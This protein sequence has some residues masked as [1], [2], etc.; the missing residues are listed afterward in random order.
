VA[1]AESLD[2]ILINAAITHPLREWLIALRPNG[3]LMVPFAIGESPASWKSLFVRI[4]RMESN[5][6]AEP[7]SI[8]N[9]YPS[10]TMRSVA[11]QARLAAS[12]ASKAIGGLRSLR[13]DPHVET[14]TCIVHSDHF[15]LS[16]LD[17]HQSAAAS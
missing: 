6:S 17:A 12:V 5:F 15:C 8:F 4:K 1:G 10:A 16:A 14:A 2:A 13:I 11:L 9:L 7:Y 3:T